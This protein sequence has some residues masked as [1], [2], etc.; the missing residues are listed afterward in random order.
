MCTSFVNRNDNQSDLLIAMN[1]DNNGWKFILDTSDPHLFVVNVD[2]GYGKHLSFGIN[3]EE[4]FVNN[5]FVDSNGKGCYK[6][7]SKTRKLISSLVDD[8]LRRNISIENLDDYFDVMEFV[9]SPNMSC[10]NLIVDQDANIWVVEPGRGIIKNNASASNYFI[11]TNF[12]LIDFANGKKYSDNSYDRYSAVK[13]VL[14]KKKNL[15]VNDAFEILKNVKQ[16][17]EWKTDFSMVYSKKEQTVY[18]CFNSGFEK[19][20]T[21]TFAE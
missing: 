17:G 1:F 14:D 7:Q 10:H 20:M 5:L 8:I 11:M 2:A 15:S 16:D 21:Y 18:Y 9:N 4:T 3:A 12:S 13:S 19:I 6:R